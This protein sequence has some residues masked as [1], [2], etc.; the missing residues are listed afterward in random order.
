[1][2]LKLFPEVI[3]AQGKAV[4]NRKK[5]QKNGKKSAKIS[6]K[7]SG[8]TGFLQRLR[9]MSAKV[10]ADTYHSKNDLGEFSIFFITFPT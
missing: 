10:A 4:C 8:K 1:M 5:Q 9:I 3:I 2:R 7:K 6:F